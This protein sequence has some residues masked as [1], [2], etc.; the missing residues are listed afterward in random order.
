MADASATP[1]GLIELVLVLFYPGCGFATLGFD[2]RPFQGRGT[3]GAMPTALCEH[4]CDVIPVAGS[5]PV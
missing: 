3:P 4:V 2:I 5:R 1:T